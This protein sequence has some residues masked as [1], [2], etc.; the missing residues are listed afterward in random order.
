MPTEY[1]DSIE[2]FRAAIDRLYDHCALID[3]P[4]QI[5]PYRVGLSDSGGIACKHSS[6]IEKIESSFVLTPS[7]LLTLS[8]R[9]EQRLMQGGYLVYE[10]YYKATHR[11][12][13]KKRTYDAYYFGIMSDE[14]A[15]V[16]GLRH[17]AIEIKRIG[18]VWFN[19]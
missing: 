8:D 11:F 3:E 2:G 15:V 18:E 6:T 12:Y 1:L 7:E 19:R 16:Q 13:I 10:K 17:G 9:F 5:T 4:V 14:E